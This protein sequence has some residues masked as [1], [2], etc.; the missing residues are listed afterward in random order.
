LKFDFGD[1][2]YLRVPP[3]KGVQQFGAKGK[4][5]PRYIG[6]YE[7]IEEC[8]PLAYRLQLPSQLAAIHDIFHVSQLKKGVRVPTK[9]VKQQEVMIEPD[10]SYVEQPIKI[11]DQKERSIR[12]AVIKMYKIQWNHHTEEEATWKTESYLNQRFPS[13]LSSIKGTHFPHLV[14]IRILGRDSC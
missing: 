12:R 3:T 4:L 1:H 7:I 11:L 6:P 8:G 5:A 13:F 14:F 2:V 9:I 10:L